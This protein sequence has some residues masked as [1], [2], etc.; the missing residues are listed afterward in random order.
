MQITE[1]TLVK[2]K[3]PCSQQVKLIFL[4]FICINLSSPE[5]GRASGMVTVRGFPGGPSRLRA[6]LL[7]EATRIEYLCIP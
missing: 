4:Q 7:I 2:T 1:A 5:A 3:L 6:A